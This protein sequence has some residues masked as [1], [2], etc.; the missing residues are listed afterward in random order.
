VTALARLA[1]SVL[2][3][4]FPGDA[5][6][7]APLHE[8]RDLAPGAIVLFSW[9]LSMDPGR[10]RLLVGAI[11]KVLD[12]AVFAIDQEGGRVARLRGGAALAL[13]SA[14]AIAAS[15]EP[16]APNLLALGVAGEL[17]AI[18]VDLNLAPVADL[19]LATR[20]TV[21][22]TRAYSDDPKRAAAL[23]A[24]TVHGLLRGGIAATLKHFPGHGA[25]AVDSHVALPILEV[26][27]ATLRAREFVPFEAGIAAGA[28]AV[29]LGH[30]M[31]PAIDRECPA[32]LS[33][34]V[35]GDVLRRELGFE[36]VVV[37]DCL[38]MD[39]IVK[40][41][42]TVRAAV[43]ALAAG[44]DLVAISHD[45]SL[46]RAARD[47]IVAAVESGELS[48]AALEA[49]ALR[50]AGLRRDLWAPAEE[51][52]ARELAQHIARR[53]ITL[54]R[55]S[56]ALRLDRPVNVV[57]FEGGSGD[58]VAAP[59]DSVPL[60]L[61]L[62]RRRVQA[63]LLRVALAPDDGMIENLCALIASQRDRSVV[64]VMRRAHIHEGQAR[65]VDALLG[66]A[67]EAIVV[68]ALEPFDVPRFPQARTVLCTYGDEEL[69]IDALA[70]VLAGIAAPAGS[71]PVVLERVAT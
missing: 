37:T 69:A 7:N 11:S 20:G 44:A 6:K 4:G 50:V 43:L 47:A 45:L 46:A 9:N 53:A 61:A 52:D 8:L 29:M 17:R 40:G 22:G 71:L 1:G 58:G 64:I 54:L 51:F 39:A 16:S 3:V 62:R 25:T 59:S 32:S 38:Q 70:D 5:P 2:C 66:L 31:V 23:V 10:N 12:G 13:P 60:H 35:I 26:D 21:I 24:A 56:A 15:G 27:G 57:S 30:L 49:S 42:G 19:A 63:E 34:R 28:R 68:S 41:V 14:M 65:A 36:G 67:P 33:R 55:G 18:G 48:R